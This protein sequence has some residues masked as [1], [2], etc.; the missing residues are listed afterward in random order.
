MARTKAEKD[1]A[2]LLSLLER[3]DFATRWYALSKKYDKSGKLITPPIEEQQA[4]V[5]GAGFR[6][7]TYNKRERFWAYRE[8]LNES[9]IVEL[10]VNLKIDVIVETILVLKTK[11][12]HVGDTFP[13]HALL[14]KRR[15]DPGYVNDPPYPHPRVANG[16]QLHA[17]LVDIKAFYEDIKTAVLAEKGWEK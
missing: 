11:H 17:A 6:N 14:L 13:M 7:A 15:T 2:T 3:I 10:G 16:K 1:D 8:N 9:P 4:A 5:E 12:G